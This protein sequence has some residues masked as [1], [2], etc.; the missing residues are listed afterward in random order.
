L[1]ERAKILCVAGSQQIGRYLIDALRVRGCLFM[2]ERP[3]IADVEQVI[4]AELPLDVQAGLVNVSVVALRLEESDRC[5]G[6]RSRRYGAAAYSKNPRFYK[7]VRK[8]DSL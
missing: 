4:T 5:S 3:Q 1:R 6:F 7:L 8:L 2:P